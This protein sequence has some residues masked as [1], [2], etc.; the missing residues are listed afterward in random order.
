[1]VILIALAATLFLV[2]LQQNIYKKYWNKNLDVKITY[3][4]HFCIAGEENELE[5]VITNDK[6]LPLPMLHVK[7][8]M[9]KS[10]LFENEENSSVT[11]NYYRDDVFAVMGHQS[12]TRT[13]KF[14]CSKRGCFYMHNSNITA[15]DLFLQ[16]TLTD[17]RD[18]HNVIHVFPKK[19][20]VSFFDIPFNTITGSHVTQSTLIEDPFEFKGI[21]E[22]QPYDS[23]KKINY[24]STA[25]QGKLQVNT[26]FMTSSQEVIL[27][28]N[29]DAQTF[30]RDDRLTEAIISLTSSIAEK[31]IVSGIPVGIQTN[32]VDTFT[33][34]QISVPSGGGG[35]HMVSLDTALSRINS[36][37]TNIPF[38]NV[39]SGCFS[40]I[41]ERTYYIVISNLRS[42]EIIEIYEE[43]KLKGAY[44]Y[45]IV[46]ELKPFPVNEEIRDMI[47]WDIEY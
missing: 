28:L 13:L 37:G 34:Q 33:N 21:R 43:A 44:S 2:W 47:K 29:L 7:F 18:N 40:N 45:F 5:E 6:A 30:S 3:K 42:K 4:N 35:S 11:D 26:F 23:M 41:N 38:A 15:S 31:F 12:V 20:D 39:L 16:S 1:M 22:Y 36:T 19:I 46:P 17:R 27:L 25:R 8:D 24:K 10:F 9:P 32:G 14:V